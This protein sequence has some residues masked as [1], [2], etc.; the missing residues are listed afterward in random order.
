MHAKR[1]RMFHGTRSV[2]HWSRSTFFAIDAAHKSCVYNSEVFDDFAVGAMIRTIRSMWSIRSKRSV[3]TYQIHKHGSINDSPETLRVLIQVLKWALLV[4]C[5]STEM[6]FER[7]DLLEQT[8][9]CLVWWQHEELKG[10]IWW[11]WISGRLDGQRM[12]WTL[13]AMPRR[14]VISLS[15]H[16]KI[17]MVLIQNGQLVHVGQFTWIDGAGTRTLVAYHRL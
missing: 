4:M 5:L 3:Q 17:S 10:R 16:N 11:I 7:P 13:T 1:R 8:F 14:G 15:H 2:D 9:A 6:C 12:L